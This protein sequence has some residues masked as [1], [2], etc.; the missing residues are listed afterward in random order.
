MCP[1]S[2]RLRFVHCEHSISVQFHLLSVPESLTDALMKVPLLLL[3]LLAAVL[4]SLALGA[5]LQRTSTLFLLRAT[6]TTNIFVEFA[7]V[8]FGLLQLLEPLGAAFRWIVE[9]CAGTPY[10]H[11]VEPE[12]IRQSIVVRSIHLLK[13]ALALEVVGLAVL[14]TAGSVERFLHLLDSI[15][16][17]REYGLAYV[18]V[19]DSRPRHPVARSCEHITYSYQTMT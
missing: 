17:G 13:K 14:E 4:A 8:G 2:R 5:L 7:L 10:V 3:T 16:T 12:W 1:F 19:Q 11:A 6:A 9:H 18:T 15:W